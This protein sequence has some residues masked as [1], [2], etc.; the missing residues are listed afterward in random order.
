MRPAVMLSTVI[1]VVAVCG[2]SAVTTTTAAS[3]T[4]PTAEGG[5]EIDTYQ[6]D[7]GLNVLGNYRV[8]HNA[9]FHI[10]RSGWLPATACYAL[11]VRGSG[12][13]DLLLNGG[14]AVPGAT[15]RAVAYGSGPIFPWVWANLTAAT[16][17]TAGDYLMLQPRTPGF[18]VSVVEASCDAAHYYC[19]AAA[20]FNV[21][22]RPIPTVYSDEEVGKYGMASASAFYGSLFQVNASGYV[23]SFSV[24]LAP[25]SSGVLVSLMWP[26]NNTVVLSRWVFPNQASPSREPVVLHTI[27]LPR[28][29][30]VRVD[31]GQWL[32]LYHTSLDPTRVYSVRINSVTGVA[33]TRIVV[34]EA[35]TMA[36][37]SNENAP[38]ASLPATSFQSSLTV[39]AGAAGFLSHIDIRSSAPLYGG[40]SLHVVVVRP[41]GPSPPFVTGVFSADGMDSGEWHGVELQSAVAVYPTDVVVVNQTCGGAPFVAAVTL[42]DLHALVRLQVATAPVEW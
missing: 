21:R 33:V 10:S 35:E 27:D 19:D 8:L 40:C 29:A 4:S 18:N 30:W 39:A 36:T 38:L 5:G 3:P 32:Q 11:K 20:A 25:F 15:A 42:P 31:P 2:S 22:V 26:Q 37:L 12:M 1:A 34:R 6:Q 28:D 9:T 16:P 23:T 24:D 41:Y 13:V 7:D 14:S 17:V